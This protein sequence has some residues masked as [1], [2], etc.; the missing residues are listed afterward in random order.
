VTE[1]VCCR[2]GQPFNGLPSYKPSLDEKDRQH[3]NERVCMRAI[4]KEVT[5]LRAQLQELLDELQLWGK[6]K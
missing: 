5:K 4:S 2:C 1:P 3:D 6:L